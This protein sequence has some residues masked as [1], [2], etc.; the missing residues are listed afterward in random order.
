M[1]FFVEGT[2]SVSLD[3]VDVEQATIIYPEMS[4]ADALGLYAYNGMPQSLRKL[5]PSMQSKHRWDG[6]TVL[7]YVL[8]AHV[9]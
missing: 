1:K 2:L 8:G 7:L 3:D 4:H 9:K 5:K 6:K